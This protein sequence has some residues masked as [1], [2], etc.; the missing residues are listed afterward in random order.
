[1]WRQQ[2]RFSKHTLQMDVDGI[3]EATCVCTAPGVP[4]QSGVIILVGYMLR[5]SQAIFVGFLGS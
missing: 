5:C 2:Q 1:M 3:L 4:R